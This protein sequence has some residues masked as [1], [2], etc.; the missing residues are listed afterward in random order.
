MATYPA[1]DGVP[2][3]GSEWILTRILR[4][5]LGFEGLVLSEGNGIESLIYERLAKDYQQAGILALKAGVDVGIS[6]EP[7]YMGDMIRSV[8]EGLVP[9]ALLD[10]AAD[11]G[12]PGEWQASGGSVDRGECSRGGRGVAAGREGRPGGGRGPFRGF[13]P[14]RAAPRNHAKARR[15]FEVLLG[16]S[17]RDIRLKGTFEITK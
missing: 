10:R 14:D 9:E 6:Y 4:E 15:S 11:R 17:S 5:E 1:I 2:A 3:H 13:Q 8:E 7:G 12:G 16:R